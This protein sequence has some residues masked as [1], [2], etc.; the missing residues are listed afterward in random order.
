LETSR[1]PAL[2]K[3]THAWKS[4]ALDARCLPLTIQ[5]AL[6]P[7]VWALPESVV[8]LRDRVRGLD[9]IRFVLACIVAI[10][11]IGAFPLLQGLDRSPTAGWLVKGLYDVTINGPAA[12]IVF[13]VI[14]GFCI[15]YPYRNGESL[16]PLQYYPRRYLRILV[17]LGGAIVL[18][19]LVDVELALLDDSILWSIVCEEIYY[20]LYP[21]LLPL[22]RRFGWA[23][24]L[25][26][27]FAGSVAVA[28]PNPTAGNYPSSGWQLNWLLG[29]P[30]WLLGC[31]LAE[32]SDTLDAPVSARTIWSWRF[33]VWIVSGVLLGL[34][35]HSPLTD[36]HT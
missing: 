36:P 31:L 9:S 19:K 15:H 6:Q 22:R 13:F 12:V 3:T 4:R 17:P 24:I 14:S 27:S 5:P 10:G 20:L 29:L 21:F 32:R 8:Q 16:R 26:L 25:A 35:F 34:R 30:C 2:T 33:G 23:P 7:D 11:H 28:W 1:L 18:A